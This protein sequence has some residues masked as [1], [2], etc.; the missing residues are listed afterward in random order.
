MKYFIK[1]GTRGLFHI[2]ESGDFGVTDYTP[3]GIDWVYQVEETGTLT[4][5]L[6]TEKKT[7]D[8]KK[9]DFVVVFYKKPGLKDPV[10]IIHSDEWND[11]ILGM[12]QASIDR[13]SE[14]FDCETES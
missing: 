1:P 12:R 3:T 6:E 9:D 5:D 8:V 4:I 13:A 7:Y 10:I 11:N 14:K 2:D